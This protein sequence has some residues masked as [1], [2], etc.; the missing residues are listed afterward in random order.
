M[1]GLSTPTAIEWII[2]G[3]ENIACGY[4]D[5]LQYVIYDV[6]TVRAIQ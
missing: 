1:N 5:S 2:K 4:S 3:Y 6:A